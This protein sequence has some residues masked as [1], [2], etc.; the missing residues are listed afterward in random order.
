LK[1]NSSSSLA[2]LILVYCAWNAHGLAESWFQNSYFEHF[3][4][5]I[6]TIWCL[7]VVYYVFFL[8]KKNQKE[9]LL[10]PVQLTA[11]LFFSLA[12]SIGELRLFEYAGLAVAISA[13]IPWS[14][15]STIWLCLSVIWMP[16]S[17]WIASH[18]VP[19]YIDFTFIIRL[20]LVFLASFGLILKLRS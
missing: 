19:T 13:F 15:M 1:I 7:P 18:L 12:G 10:H 17:G 11:A 16:I 20:I 3:S 14:I 2:L 6:L 9:F 8:K 4:W 5:V